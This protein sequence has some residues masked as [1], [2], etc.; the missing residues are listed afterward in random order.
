[1]R[2]CRTWLALGLVPILSAPLA[3]RAAVV[4]KW[5]DTDGV[6]HFSDQPVEGAERIETSSGSN[7]GVL[8]DPA[9]N[10]TAQAAPKAATVADIQVSITSPAREQTFSGEDSVTAALSVEPA[11]KPG[12]PF[13][14]TWTLNGAPVIEGADAMFFTLPPALTTARGIYTLG[15]TYTDP[16]S[17]QTKSADPVTFNVLR[18][19]TLSPQHK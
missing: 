14:V 4:Y 10:N 3:L 1:M 9:P 2:L 6:V 13:S 8:S 18:P 5:I 7:H 19:S 15:A 17:G 12:H 11:P 16:E